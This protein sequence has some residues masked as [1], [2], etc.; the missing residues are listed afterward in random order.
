M[1]PWP[2]EL[3]WLF[4]ETDPEGI[5]LERDARFVLARV[6]EKGRLQDVNWLL[7]TYGRERIHAFFRDEGHPEISRRTEYFWRAVFDAED[8]RWA[9]PSPW[10]VTSAAPWVD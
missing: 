2:P 3:H 6:L 5:D 1:T 7:R 8:E 10:R 9:S 4:W